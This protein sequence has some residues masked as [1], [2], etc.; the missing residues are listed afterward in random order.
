MRDNH[1]MHILLAILLAVPV[2]TEL[3]IQRAT[4]AVDGGTVDP[5]RDLAPLLERLRATRDED[6]KEDLVRV[7]EDLGEY[8]SHR[9]AAV[10]AYL[11]E[12]APAALLVV[13]KNGLHWS[14]RS[15]A[16]MVLRDLNVSDAWLDEGIAVGKA[17]EKPH[18]QHA[19]RLLEQWKESRGGEPVLPKTSSNE[20]A[21]LEVLRRTGTRVSM[22]SLSQAAMD[23]QTEIVAALLDTGMD[24]NAPLFGNRRILDSAITGCAIDRNPGARL[25][26]I[27][28]LIAR[29]A[30]VKHKDG[31]DN[32]ILMFAVD[33]PVPV[34]AKLIDAGVP[35]D[36]ENVMKFSALKSAFA[37]GKWD[38]AAL[39][40]D[41]G[42][43]MTK[44]EI[45]D[46]FF[47]KPEDPEKLA[48]LRRATK[49]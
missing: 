28:L 25:A 4:A 32:T 2:S 22:D 37:K 45:D 16:L 11:R 44:K 13:A 40:V 8:D 31:N 6:E 34:V 1:G 5:A 10:K 35:I 38:V 49:K 47:E 17:D 43:R 41:R 12:H 33:C 14:L 26:T 18:V 3:L 36:A 24:V 20:Q 46:L 7:I 19:G 27:E 21:A 9:P 23:A 48:L 15:K 30:D 39:L 42:A 29:G